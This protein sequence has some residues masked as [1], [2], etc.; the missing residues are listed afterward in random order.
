MENYPLIFGIRDPIL[1]AG[2]VAGVEINGRALMR[3][4]DGGFWIDGVN[5][6]AISVGGKSPDEA[7]LKFREDYR[8]ILFDFA[9]R[10]D[11]F[12]D[13]KKEVERFFWEETPGEVESWLRAVERMKEDPHRGTGWLPRQEQYPEPDV[14][15][16]CFSPE[17]V[18]PERNA[19]D[20]IP[21]A[22]AA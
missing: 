19:E 9:A 13:F 17:Q 11:S 18:K 10:A 21:V 14:K 3:E 7:W 8:M 6:G 1:G 12:D 5:P 2:F 22:T 20:T 16:L 15:V 4:E